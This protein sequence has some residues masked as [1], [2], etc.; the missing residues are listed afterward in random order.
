MIPA[1]QTV[2]GVMP[3][4]QRL[5]DLEE[6]KEPPQQMLT[7][8]Q[9]D[10]NY[11]RGRGNNHLG[12]TYF[13]DTNMSIS[14][15]AEVDQASSQPVDNQSQI[16]MGSQIG[17]LPGATQPTTDANSVTGFMGLGAKKVYGGGKRNTRPP[18]NQPKNGFDEQ[19]GSSL[20][21]I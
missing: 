17:L 8:G 21:G 6:E 11:Q 2:Q 9:L 3:E 18:Q 10:A 15:Q 20:A 12:A 1:E 19:I 13:D 7:P 5:R 14:G 16:S 4:H